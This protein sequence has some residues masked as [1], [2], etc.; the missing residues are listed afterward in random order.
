M[1]ELSEEI[2]AKIYNYQCK[3][4]I[5]PNIIE[6]HPSVYDSLK[7]STERFL[8]KKDYQVEKEKIDTF[9]GVKIE[10][11]TDLPVMFRVGYME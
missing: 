11:I 6:M 8:C 4:S 2:A 5:M 10:I 1:N 3:Y 9:M 7:N